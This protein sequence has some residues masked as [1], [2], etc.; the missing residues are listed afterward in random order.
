MTRGFEFRETGD[1]WWWRVRG[2]D[3]WHSGEPPKMLIQV[4]DPWQLLADPL[5]FAEGAARLELKL[6]H[7][8]TTPLGTVVDAHRL[9]GITTV[10]TVR[11]VGLGAYGDPDDSLEV[12]FDCWIEQDTGLP[13]KVEFH[14]APPLG[15][16]HLFDLNALDEMAIIEPADEALARNRLR[17]RVV[18]TAVTAPAREV[19][20]EPQTA[21]VVGPPD[22]APV[23][24]EIPN[25]VAE[26]GP[27]RETGPPLADGWLRHVAPT[28]GYALELPADWEVAPPVDPSDG[29]GS[30]LP[31]PA[32]GRWRSDA[33]RNTE[34][35]W[36]SPSTGW[37]PLE[38]RTTRRFR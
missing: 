19:D 28:E 3:G 15:V 2:A 35:F 25:E 9:S 26:A 30:H 32:D 17:V 21:A 31:A 22:D 23:V 10:G 6:P 12:L 34:H 13:L 27:Y 4:I 14:G 33:G 36:R 38:R 37:S 18:P 11:S 29:R 24:V 1:R 16:L 5:R 20:V 8:V 7:P